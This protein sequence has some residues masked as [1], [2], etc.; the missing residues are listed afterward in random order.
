[1]NRKG[2]KRKKEGK[3]GGYIG[4]AREADKGGD[5]GTGKLKRGKDRKKDK[6]RVTRVPIR[7]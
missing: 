1:M 6:K 7:N 2:D 4:R 5:T 3:K